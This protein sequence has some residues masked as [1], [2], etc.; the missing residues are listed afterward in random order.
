[1]KRIYF[2]PATLAVAGLVF[3]LFRNPAPE[4][5]MPQPKETISEEA[6]K[7]LKRKEWIEQM[8]KAAPGVDWRAMDEQAM[9]EMYQER[10]PALQAAARSGREK[11]GLIE[12]LADGNLTGRWI[13]K[14][15]NNLSGR[16]H[17]V[18]VDFEK[19]IL[20][21]A[22]DGGQV[23]MGGL[24][25][26]NWKSLSDPYRIDNIQFIRAFPNP[27]GGTRVFAANH[28]VKMN[29]TDDEGVTWLKSEGL[30]SYFTD[31]K[32]L[33]AISQPDGTLYLLAWKSSYL[34]LFRSKDLGTSFQRMVRTA[35]SEYSDLWTNRF[36]KDSLYLIDRNQ[37]YKMADSVTFQKIAE[38][39]LNFAVSEI[40][41]IQLAGCQTDSAAFLYAMYRLEKASRFFGVDDDGKTWRFRG[42]IAEGPFM[43]NS[44]GVSPTAPRLLGFGSME[45][46]RSE[47]G[48]PTW[49]HVNGW[50]EYY[51]DMN[52]KLHA[53]IPEI[54]FF[55]TPTNTDL[56][57][58]STDG[59]TF[60][61]E[62]QMK[63]VRNVSLK[64]LN[65]SQYYTTYTHRT[66]NNVIYA[67]AQDQGFQRATETSEGTVSF[68]QTISGDYGHIVSGDGGVSLWTDY[69]GFAM[70]YPDAAGSNGMA[71][72]DFKGK[73]HFWMPPLM[74]DPY[75]PNRCWIA[76]GT[77]TTGN[78]LWLLEY[79]SGTIT[80]TE[81]PFDFS[82]LNKTAWISA[83]AWSPINR[84]YRY[85]LNSD[86]KLFYSTDRGT[87]WTAS[88]STGPGSHYF[89]GNA[90]V[91]SPKDINTIYLAG[92][93]YSGSSVWVSHDGGETFAKMNNGLK[94]TL[95][96]EM[97]SN[98]DGSLLFAA[99][100]VAPWVYVKRLDKWF[101]L[102]GVGAPQQTWWSVDYVPS[103]KTAR[104]G[105]Y[106]RG[107]WDF[108]IESFTGME[109]I[110]AGT[111]NIC[112]KTWPN[113]ASDQL[114]IS[115][116]EHLT[117]RTVISLVALDGRV[118]KT[119]TYAD[120]IPPESFVT[121]SLTNVP[122]GIYVV[123]VGGQFS[124]VVIGSAALR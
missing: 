64:D 119:V 18:D 96:F 103:M 57:Y 78:H 4:N 105:T 67:G 121:L 61:S 86:G 108:R 28:Q 106:G 118:V 58:I 26:E 35:G 63:T 32:L 84:D 10:L 22:S 55:R 71:T 122:A 70:Y 30:T 74:A 95:I 50:G 20:Y 37:V 34:Y 94:N 91:P 41:Q 52:G 38:V 104:F 116:D 72:W 82:G 29:Y 113:P 39:P 101:D 5:L 19:N 92:S 31:Y 24:K 27:A 88:T 2:L 36:G 114:N 44:F 75:F 42:E 111:K 51:A 56:T 1:M 112:I 8:H 97:V 93:G 7:Q 33:R 69:P 66:R 15:S 73:E 124:K 23:W 3:I 9:E 76:C 98:E 48:G 54:E 100:Q 12:T 123:R 11:S 65:I 25:G 81:M 17:C 62:D 99:S 79:K 53:D 89:Y 77:S 83:M 45:A 43:S 49:V 13:E 109:E 120:G 87:T 59:G 6:D 21:A 46:F 107:I 110:L 90:I 14:G 115:L 60:V 40:R 117:G 102:S 85:V 68:E 16:V 80:H 47:N